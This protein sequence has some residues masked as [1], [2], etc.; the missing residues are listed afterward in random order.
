MIVIVFGMASLGL[1][2]WLQRDVWWSGVLV[3]AGTSLV[4]FA[5]L[6]LIGRGIERRLDEVQ[7]TQRNISERQDEAESR[8]DSLAEEVQQAQSAFHLAREELSKL[9]AARLAEIRAAD[10]K[11]FARVGDVPSH[12]ATFAALLR[13]AELGLISQGGCRVRIQNSDAYLWFSTPIGNES[14]H[15]LPDSP[16][17]LHLR[18]ERISGHNLANL[19][20]PNYLS[21]ADFLVEL[22]QT[23]QKTGYYPGDNLFLG[24]EVFTDLAETLLLAHKYATTSDM[25]PIR[26]VIQ[27]CPPQWVLTESRLVSVGERRAGYSILMSRLHEDWPRHMSEKPWLDR[28]SFDEAYETAVALYEAGRLGV[29]APACGEKSPS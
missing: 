21:A 23:L 11:V 3:N 13:A 17:D 20:W 22:G 8:I 26:Q 12:E 4:L 18:I 6:L 27:F 25:V 1:S 2:W 16:G 14:F 29:K 15:E 19:T 9:V 5:P 7:E 24:G 10:S 28:D